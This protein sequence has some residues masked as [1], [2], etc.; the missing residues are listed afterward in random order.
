[1]SFSRA[2]LRSVTQTVS[3]KIWTQL[4]GSI[5][6][7]NNRY[8]RYAYEEKIQDSGTITKIGKTCLNFGLSFSYSL[9][10][11]ALWKVWIHSSLRLILRHLDKI[12]LATMIIDKEVNE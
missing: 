11:N 2:L 4:T 5:S 10:S 8:D 12:T 3:T 1:M 7:D 9:W 6:F